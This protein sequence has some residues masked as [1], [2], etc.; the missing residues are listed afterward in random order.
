MDG[1][2][3]G[4]AFLIDEFYL[5]KG[6]SRDKCPNEITAEILLNRSQN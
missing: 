1:R 2:R 6:G 5:H 4:A 3:L